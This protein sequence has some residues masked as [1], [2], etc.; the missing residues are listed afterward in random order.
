MWVTFFLK[1]SELAMVNTRFTHCLFNLLG[2]S[3][4]RGFNLRKTNA[5]NEGWLADSFTDVKSKK[6]EARPIGTL[7]LT[8]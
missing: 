7:I 4:E 1:M 2:I 8:A 3:H 5:A 6:G